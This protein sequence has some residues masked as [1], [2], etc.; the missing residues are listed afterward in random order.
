MKHLKFDIWVASHASQFNL[1]KKHIPGDP[2]NP[3]AFADR[4]GYDQALENVYKVYQKK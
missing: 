4:K 2:Y 3:E 1:H